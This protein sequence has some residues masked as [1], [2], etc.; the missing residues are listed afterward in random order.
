M[1]NDSSSPDEGDVGIDRATVIAQSR[2]VVES[3]TQ[4]IISAIDN[5][6]F[7]LNNWGKIALN[8]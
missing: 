6:C 8:L 5:G 3:D 4:L 1:T 7:R 2:L